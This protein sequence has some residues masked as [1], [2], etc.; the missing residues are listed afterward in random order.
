MSDKPVVNPP[1]MTHL[2]AHAQIDLSTYTQL[3]TIVASCFF[4][5]CNEQLIQG[6]FQQY[7][8]DSEHLMADGVKEFLSPFQS[9]L[10]QSSGQLQGVKDD[11]A[12]FPQTVEATRAEVKQIVQGLCTNPSACGDAA[13]KRLTANGKLTG[14]VSKR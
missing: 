9:A 1:S 2:L 8:S 7:I 3:A 6:F 14:M 13:F 4:G 12:S 10:Q 11:I 5:G